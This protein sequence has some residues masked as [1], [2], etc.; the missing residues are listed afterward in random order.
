MLHSTRATCTHSLNYE[1]NF[2]SKSHLKLSQFTVNSIFHTFLKKEKKWSSI[3]QPV[4][5]FHLCNIRILEKI[6]MFLTWTII[7]NKNLFQMKKTWPFVLQITSFLPFLLG[8]CWKRAIL[9]LHIDV[10]KEDAILCKGKDENLRL[11]RY[12][13]FLISRNTSFFLVL[14]RTNVLSS[15]F[16]PVK[17]A[18]NIHRENKLQIIK[19]NITFETK[20]PC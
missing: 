3:I 18:N 13:Y 15:F 7:W 10:I 9:K 17:R 14:K 12:N 19:T 11:R 8:N 6:M 1:A 20:L 2:R 4:K 16:Y 5:W